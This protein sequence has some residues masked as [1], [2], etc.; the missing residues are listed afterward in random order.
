MTSSKSGEPYDF[1][2]L[3]IAEGIKKRLILK[4]SSFFHTISTR[5][6]FIRNI[7]PCSTLLPTDISRP[8]FSRKTI[9]AA[10]IKHFF[11]ELNRCVVLYLRLTRLDLLFAMQL[12]FQFAHEPSPTS[13]AAMEHCL[14]Y[15]LAT[16]DYEYPF[17]PSPP[18]TQLSLVAF[19]E[20]SW[21]TN[22][23]NRM[24][25]GGYMIFLGPS[26]VGALSKQKRF[27]TTS[28]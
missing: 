12:L 2:G 24:S 7:T 4:Q 21:A 27:V 14:G 15:M 20:S 26:L 1:L 18:S 11:S 28:G 6:P 23:K 22:R 10:P 25:C 13:F 16:R 17:Y 9:M 8:D 3:D 19:S 5:F